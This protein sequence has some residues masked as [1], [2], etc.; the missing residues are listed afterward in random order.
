MMLPSLL[1][2][3]FEIV[4]CSWFDYRLSTLSTL[5]STVSISLLI[6]SFHLVIYI[7]SCYIPVPF[8]QNKNT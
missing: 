6:K 5:C 7:Q 2:N 8:K 3:E 4:G 1:Q